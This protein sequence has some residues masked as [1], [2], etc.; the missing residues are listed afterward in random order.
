MKHAVLDL[1]VPISK[2]KSG[3]GVKTPIRP[4][5]HM[6]VIENYLNSIF[7]RAQGHVDKREYLE[8][9][10]M[11]DREE[12]SFKYLQEKGIEKE[13]TLIISPMCYKDQR[14]S[15]HF[16]KVGLPELKEALLKKNLPWAWSVFKGCYVANE[17]LRGAA[18]GAKADVESI[19]GASKSED[20]SLMWLD[21][22]RAA[23]KKQDALSKVSQDSVSNEELLRYFN[24][25]L[26]SAIDAQDKGDF[27]NAA[28]LYGN[29]EYV[30]DILHYRLV[31]DTFLSKELFSHAVKEMVSKYGA[32]EAL[33]YAECLLMQKA[34]TLEIFRRDEKGA[35]PKSLHGILS[36]AFTGYETGDVSSETVDII[37]AT[38][39]IVNAQE[40]EKTLRA[41][42]DA[43]YDR[44]VELVKE[45]NKARA[46]KDSD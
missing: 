23:Q 21:S 6:P 36:E 39:F 13:V 34:L 37:L 4:W 31:H 8:L 14:G 40:G 27:A 32:K 45:A 26:N 30:M 12:I 9:R 46:P 18:S 43:V 25:T 19:T 11:A 29:A 5:A 20:E 15:A 22:D 35:V 16:L 2:Y 42:C 17:L 41:I 1:N 44:R 3:N 24:L 28:K 10:K 7:I 33:T 38:K